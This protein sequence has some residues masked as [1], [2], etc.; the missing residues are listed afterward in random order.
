MKNRAA[1]CCKVLSFRSRSS[2]L[3]LSLIVTE[4]DLGTTALIGA[5]MFVIMFVA[6]A[7][8][9]ASRCCFR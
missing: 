2:A 3:L 4:V 1:S 7:Q 9:G 5:T 6:G 8:S